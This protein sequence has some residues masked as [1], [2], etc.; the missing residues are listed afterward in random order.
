MPRGLSGP[1]RS[2]PRSASCSSSSS[3]ASSFV[4]PREFSYPSLALVLEKRFPGLGDRLITAVELADVRRAAAFGYSPELIQQ[5]IAEAREPRRRG[6]AELGLPLGPPAPPALLARRTRP[7]R[8][9]ARLS[10]LRSGSPGRSRSPASPA[11]SAMSSA[12]PPSATRSCRTRPGPAARTWNMWI[13]GTGTPRRQG[14]AAAASAST[15]ASGSSPTPAPATAGDPS[16]GQT[17]LP[18]GLEASPSVILREEGDWSDADLASGPPRRPGLP[19][20]RPIA[21]HTVDLTK[22]TVDE[23]AH[24]SAP[25]IQT[26]PR[27][28]SS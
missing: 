25:R 26:W 18:L 3:P 20:E 19:R 17:L 22:L 5:T 4:S 7:G 28:I 14:R 1:L 8:L 2:S 16:P 21:H 23:V 6:A 12:L 15:R 11:A 27:S 10:R 13:S 9:V 24:Q